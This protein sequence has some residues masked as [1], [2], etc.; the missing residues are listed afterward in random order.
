MARQPAPPHPV[1]ARHHDQSRT[2]APAVAQAAPPA[3]ILCGAPQAWYNLTMDSRTHD[4]P[5]AAK[6]G[7][8]RIALTFRAQPP[9]EE[10]RVKLEAGN[11]RRIHRASGLSPQH[12][13]RVIKGSKG[14]SLHVAKRIADAAGVSLD[15]LYSYIV[16]SPELNV[17]GRRTLLDASM[18]EASVKTK[19]V[20]AAR[21][22][23]VAAKMDAK[24]RKAS[25]NN[26]RKIPRKL[27]PVQRR[28]EYVKKARAAA[29]AA[30]RSALAPAPVV[31]DEVQDL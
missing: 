21:M 9:T 3:D 27:A 23:R 19:R 29:V 25:Q 2:S 18:A 17:R 31:F 28:P 1:Q 10:T 24:V 5:S 8:H 26:V 12:I 11:Y 30:A 4:K 7:S 13:S 20:V 22:K 14:A 15:E 6:S 16:Y